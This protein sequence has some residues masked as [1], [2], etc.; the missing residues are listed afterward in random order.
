MDESER[1][2]HPLERMFAESLRR[3]ARDGAATRE[4]RAHRLVRAGFSVPCAARLVWLD[5]D[6]VN[7]AATLLE[8]GLCD[9]GEAARAVLAGR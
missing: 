4:V 9:A 1:P 2:A 5:A 3:H 6:A 8:T 7:F